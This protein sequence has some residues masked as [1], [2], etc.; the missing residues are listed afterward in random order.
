MSIWSPSSSFE[1]KIENHPNTLSIPLKTVDFLYIKPV[2]TIRVL[3]CTTEKVTTYALHV[4]LLT[5]KPRIISRLACIYDG[6]HKE[7]VQHFDRKT[8]GKY[9]FS[10]RRKRLKGGTNKDQSGTCYDDRRN[11]EMAQDRAPC[12][13]LVMAGLNISFLLPWS[14]YVSLYYYFRA[15]MLNSRPDLAL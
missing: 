15:G 8:L 14:K 7:C 11:K 6:R 10:W 3:T 4:K 9:L 12:L 1:H 5:V 2:R 13:P